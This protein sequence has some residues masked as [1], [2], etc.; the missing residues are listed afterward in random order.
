[1]WIASGDHLYSIEGCHIYIDRKCIGDKDYFQLCLAPY[2][3]TA[4]NSDDSYDWVILRE[5][6][7]IE[8]ARSHLRRITD[9]LDAPRGNVFS[10]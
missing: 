1:M 10:L 4:P 7:S 5:Y 6:T 8:Q 9:W 3:W 2:A